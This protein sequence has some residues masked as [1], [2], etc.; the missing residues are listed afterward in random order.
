MKKIYLIL[1]FITFLTNTYSQESIY[2]KIT[3]KD[4]VRISCSYIYC[5]VQPEQ[6]FQGLDFIT[7]NG[8]SSHLSKSSCLLYIP[9][10]NERIF[11]ESLTGQDIKNF[12]MWIYSILYYHHKF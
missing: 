1:L 8:I 3:D 7:V 11:C 9:E 10:T 4:T 12:Y 5:N 6:I 2:Y